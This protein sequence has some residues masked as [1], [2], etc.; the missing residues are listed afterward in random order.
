[1]PKK[2]R[3][4]PNTQSPTRNRSENRGVN[5][6]LANLRRQSSSSPRSDHSAIAAPSVP[7]VIREILQLPETP[8]PLPRFRD[9]A[10]VTG[11]YSPADRSMIDVVLKHVAREWRTL[12]P[13]ED[14]GLWALPDRSRQVLVRYLEAYHGPDVGVSDLRAIFVPDGSVESGV[15]SENA[16]LTHLHVPSSALTASTF[17]SLIS[18]LFPK[19]PDRQGLA[20]LEEEP[21]DSWDSAELDF[22]MLS[23]SPA[24]C[25][26]ADS[27]LL[28][29][30][31]AIYQGQGAPGSSLGVLPSWRHLLQLAKKMPGVTHLSLAF[32]PEP[33][34]TPNAK[35]AS[36]VGP[37]GTSIHQSWYQL[38]Y[39][40]L[41]GCAAWFQALWRSEQTL[42]ASDDSGEDTDGAAYMYLGVLT[43][44]SLLNLETNSNIVSV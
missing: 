40:D 18:M 15:F 29:I 5:E 37:Q 1:M 35:F 27:P 31:P 9:R 20:A 43:A 2:R 8:E 22:A 30:D 41:T 38:Q 44:Y 7:P 12:G 32:W 11:E 28:A 26:R 24:A 14:L 4:F 36:V 10:D 34:R 25:S 13:L 19:A 23:L 17:P 33:S 16:Y 3:H 21:Q 39:L 6:L 42:L